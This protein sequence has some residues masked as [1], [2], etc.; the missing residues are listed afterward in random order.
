M[1]YSKK[2]LRKLLIQT[3]EDRLTMDGSAFETTYEPEAIICDLPPVDLENSDMVF[4]EAPADVVAMS[5]VSFDESQ[6]VEVTGDDSEGVA[7]YSLWSFDGEETVEYAADDEAKPIDASF[8]TVMV[9]DA[10]V[11]D[12]SMWRTFTAVSEEGVVDES[13]PENNEPVVV[14]CY[15]D[16]STMTY[17]TKLEDGSVIEAKPLTLDGSD[18]GE[19]ANDGLV[20]QV[21]TLT[22]DS[23][24][25]DSVEGD[26]EITTYDIVEFDDEMVQRT[27]VPM[28][29]TTTSFESLPTWDSCD[30]NQDG[31]VSAL[32]AILMFNFFNTYFHSFFASEGVMVVDDASSIF[33]ME[34]VD[35]NGDNRFSPIDVLVVINDLNEVETNSI[36]ADSDLSLLDEGML[37]PPADDVDT[38]A[39]RIAGAWL[40]LGLTTNVTSHLKDA[41]W[42]LSVD[43]TGTVTASDGETELVADISKDGQISLN[44][45]TTEW[46]LTTI[47][48]IPTFT[49]TSEAASDS[50]WVDNIDAALLELYDSEV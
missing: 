18:L 45:V 39:S 17:V 12:K 44:G 41:S 6:I 36:I 9:D 3:L 25:G 35:I 2:M 26:S 50:D 20:Y 40:T 46:S 30:L 28:E 43:E 32:D 33:E 1:K 34:N 19:E 4:F 5:F 38:S 15:F 7:G 11:I 29:V 24:V 31:K 13:N 21:M 48:S 37:V 23:E 42:E 27:D 22:G 14:I 16:E 47:D 49:L 10:E 8:Y